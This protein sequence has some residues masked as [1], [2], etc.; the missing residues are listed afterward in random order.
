MTRL[1]G[2]AAVKKSVARPE[3]RRLCHVWKAELYPETTANRLHFSDFADWLRQHHPALLQFRSTMGPL[4]DAEQWFD[5]E[6][7]QAWRN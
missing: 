6:F 5:D 7:G 3:I 2:N 1:E 4:E